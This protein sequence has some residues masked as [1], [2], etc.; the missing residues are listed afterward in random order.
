VEVVIFRQVFFDFFQGKVAIL[1]A[2]EQGLGP[3]KE[4]VKRALLQMG[5]ERFPDGGLVLDQVLQPH[6][7]PTLRVVLAIQ[8]IGSVQKGECLEQHRNS[9]DS[10]NDFSANETAVGELVGQTAEKRLPVLRIIDMSV[11]SNGS[12]FFESALLAGIIAN[13]AA[14]FI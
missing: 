4:A 2:L 1:A 13:R 14:L 7:S 3:G 10:L 11:I 12:N 9:S 8:G 5:A 6:H